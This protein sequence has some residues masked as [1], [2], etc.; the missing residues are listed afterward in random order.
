MAT[1]LI[2]REKPLNLTDKMADR[3]YSPFLKLTPIV[4][5]IVQQ[6]LSLPDK[7]FELTN[8]LGSPLNL[9]FPELVSANLAAFRSCLDNHGVRGRIYFA[10]KANRSDSIARQLA[11]ED[12]YIEVASVEELRHAL[13]SGFRAERIQAGGPKNTEFLAL[14]L[15]HNV[16]VSIDN[17]AELSEILKLRQ[18]LTIT[19]KSSLLIRVCGFR[20]NHTQYSSKASR[21]GVSLP[22][23]YD[24]FDLLQEASDKLRLVGFAFH[25]STNSIA[26]KALA[27]ENCLALFEEAFARGFQ[28]TVLNIGG[29]FKVNYLKHE[30]DWHNYIGA[31][32]TAV[33]SKRA[34]I[35]WHG[36][37]YG[38][39]TDKGLVRGSFK[40]YS[41]Y[42]PSSGPDFLHEL[43]SYKLASNGDASIGSLLSS[44]G[45]EIWIEPGRSLLDQ[46]GITIASVN[47]LRTSSHG[48]T[49]IGLNMKRQDLCF[50][51]QEIFVDPIILSKGKALASGK[52]MPVY[53]AG[54]LCLENDL[55]YRHQTFITTLPKPGDLVVFINTAGYFMDFSATA[56]IM[57]PTAKKAAIFRRAGQFTW[58]ADEQYYPWL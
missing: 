38:F 42:E 34:P 39:R 5:P 22:D 56:S 2:D 18:Q 16:T 44:N 31:L 40:S 57:Q 32:R 14:S 10:H 17:L 15:M 35:T 23:I 3:N 50:L 55:I 11:L 58:T 6:F 49:L 20:S 54:N 9:L 28:P 45:I 41:Y 12:A 13:S 46:A 36:N 29:S 33:L 37:P 47:C 30:S 25:I 27:I 19:S 52:A 43:L 21:F 53:F 51:D 7:L 24:V 1:T 48:D 26:E 4:H 8:A